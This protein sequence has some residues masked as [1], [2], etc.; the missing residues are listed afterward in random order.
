MSKVNTLIGNPTTTL[1]D[2]RDLSVSFHQ[3]EG[4]PTDVVKHINFNIA[5]GEILALV[6]ESG[7][8]KS[9]TAQAIMGLL[10]YPMAF[11]PSGSI[12]FNGRDL[13]SLSQKETCDFRGKEISMIFQEPISALNPLHTVEKQICEILKTHHNYKRGVAKQ[14]VLELLHKVKIKC[15]EEKLYAY[16]HQLSGGQRQRVMI[17]MALAN[18][19]KLLIADEPTT[20]L[21]LTVQKEI[22]DL[23]IELKSDEQMSILIITHD[24]GVV[25]YIADRILVMKA[26]EIVEE[27][28]T[29]LLFRQPQHNY[30]K[31]LLNSRPSGSPIELGQ[32]L[33]QLPS[34]LSIENLDV[35]YAIDKPLFGK[36]KK[37]FHGLKSATLEVPVGSTLGIVGESGSG[38]STL[39]LAMLR[40]VHSSGIIHF[41]GQAIHQLKDTELKPLRKKIQI[42]FQDPFASLSPR[43]CVQEIISEGLRLHEPTLSKTEIEKRVMDI[44]LEVGLDPDAR[45]HYPHEFS[46]GQRQR[47][48]I[49]RVLILNPKVVFL[50]EPT[51]A[52]DY[53]VQ[54]RI[55]NLL[56]HLQKERNL[57]YVLISHDINII[58][59]LSH[60]IVVLSE[61]KII[62]QNTTDSVL[63]NPQHPYTQ[64]LLAATLH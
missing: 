18:K 50:D 34:I 20:A 23:L 25:R 41:S 7:S 5:D 42:V 21:D 9:I 36:P 13:L 53:A 4:R 19:P 56:R 35:Q 40:L 31:L 37:I 45:H 27:N 26:G 10:P 51:S 39:A 24:L 14:T 58:K 3:N 48:A 63:K 60:Q 1:L 44:M 28:N 32:P 38:K 59:V 17:A 55:I 52:L 43:S 61:G 8:G 64:K 2:V 6:G 33:K 12:Q 57:T 54:A 16:P 47:I 22:M 62:E 49:A 29:D 30:T 11:H 15:P 46:G